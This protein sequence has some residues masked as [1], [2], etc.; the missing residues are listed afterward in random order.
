MSVF[1][2]LSL[3]IRNMHLL[4]L[5]DVHYGVFSYLRDCHGSDVPMSTGESELIE[6]T[7]H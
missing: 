1:V 6:G 7:H 2:T 3:L 4:S 5:S